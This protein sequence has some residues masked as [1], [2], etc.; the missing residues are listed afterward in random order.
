MSIGVADDGG[1][2]GG[3]GAGGGGS[4]VSVTLRAL[5]AGNDYAARDGA[6]ARLNSIREMSLGGTT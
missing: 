3:G 4:T 1:G 6:G 5:V 2:V